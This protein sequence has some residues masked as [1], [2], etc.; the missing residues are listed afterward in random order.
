M[1]APTVSQYAAIEALRS[2]DENVVKMRNEYDR[3]RRVMLDGFRKMGLECFEALGA[4]YLFPCIK[5]TGLSSDDFC[6][7]L[8][9]E[10]KV[11]VVSGTALGECGEGF[12]RCSYAYSVDDI[13]RALE[14]IS[15]FVKKYQ[16]GE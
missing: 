12:I 10:E 1:C 3:R 7:K 15:V 13:K 11:A 9:M 4:F 8:L 5:S 16:K 2:C 6:E 14:K